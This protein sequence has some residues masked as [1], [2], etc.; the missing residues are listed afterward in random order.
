MKN[1]R[2][3]SNSIQ[4]EAE[5]A[6]KLQ[7]EFAKTR[8]AIAAGKPVGKSLRGLARRLNGR[9]CRCDPE[10]RI[11]L[12][13]ATVRRLWDDWRRGGEVPAAFK[14]NFYR[15]PTALTAHVLVRFADYISASQHRSMRAAWQKFCARPGAFGHSR[16]KGN[17]RGVSYDMLCHTFH[18]ANFYLIQQHLKTIQTAQINLARARLAVIADLRNRLPDRPTRRRVKRENTFEI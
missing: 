5:R 15:H 9:P 16:R 4:W 14:L 10:R 12:S 2:H 7:Y 3:S 11:K 18:A 1:P 13:A 17:L 6:Q 8:R